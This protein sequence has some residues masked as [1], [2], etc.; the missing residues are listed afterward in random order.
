MDT[1]ADV[2]R[3][4]GILFLFVHPEGCHAVRLARLLKKCG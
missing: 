1:T 3:N 2:G 4:A